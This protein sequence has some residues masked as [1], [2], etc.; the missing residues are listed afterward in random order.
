M[1]FGE[2]RIQPLLYQDDVGAPCHNVSLARVQAF[3]LASLMQEK[4]LLAHPD[5][6]GYL[7]LGTKTYTEQI[8]KELK[9]SPIDFGKFKLQEKNKDKYLSQIFES[10]P[11]SSALATVQKRV[12][13]IIGGAIE[14]K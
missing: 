13:K 10:N 7:I 1:I 9:G 2:T 8:R 14:I 6:T 12:G 5:K 11:A 4:S 3:L